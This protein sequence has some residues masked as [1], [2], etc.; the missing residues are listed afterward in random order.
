MRNKQLI[1]IITV[2]YNSEKT[3]KNTIE[4]VFNQSCESIEYI[5]IDG[6]STDRTLEIIE[7]Y[8]KKAKEKGITYKWI[9][10]VDNGIYDAM[11]KGIDL[12][13]GNWVY[14]L[15][16]DDILF[17]I[18]NKVSEYL[19]ENY[20]FVYGDVY[21]PGKGIV[22]SG[23]F[24]K[25][26]LVLKNICHQSIF[27]KKEILQQEKFSLKYKLLS[28]YAMNIKLFDESKVKYIPVVIAKYNDLDGMSSVN[29]D[30]D[31]KRDKLFL[32]KNNLGFF[33][34][35]F[36]VSI[37]IMGKVVG[38]LGIKN[39]IKNIIYRKERVNG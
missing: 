26:K 35:L 7:S 25:V 37:K 24:N 5:I 39:T 18:L 2:S 17:D 10:E 9:S 16:S 4:S 14:F 27:Y 12:A 1:S 28:D 21:M 13:Q 22:Y 32:V 33:Y 6:K 19:K 20:S 23:K 3:I 34:Y 8:E 15:G 29:Y 36:L 30:L 31:F 11:N 38:V